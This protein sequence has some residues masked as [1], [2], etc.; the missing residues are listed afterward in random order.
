MGKKCF[1]G[2]RGL[3]YRCQRCY[4]WCSPSYSILIQW[5]SSNSE[6]YLNWL[7]FVFVGYIFLAIRIAAWLFEGF[8]LPL[9]FDAFVLQSSITLLSPWNSDECFCWCTYLK[10]WAFVFVYL[11]FRFQILEPWCCSWNST[12]AFVKDHRLTN[13]QRTSY[14]NIFTKEHGHRAPII[15]NLNQR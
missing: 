11:W 10:D 4:Y 5:Q 8:P 3:W 2:I 15:W 12:G 14:Q 7:C 1:C 13:V 6:V 9:K